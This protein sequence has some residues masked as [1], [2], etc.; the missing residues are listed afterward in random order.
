SY[1]QSIAR[2]L[3]GFRD[4]LTEAG[5]AFDPERHLLDLKSPR[6]INVAARDFVEAHIA[7]QGLKATAIFCVT[8]LVA[9]GTIQALNAR[10]I[11]VPEDIS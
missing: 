1:R 7:R 9:L 5:V 4:A 8:D 6:L 2:R 3:D 10:G 11:R